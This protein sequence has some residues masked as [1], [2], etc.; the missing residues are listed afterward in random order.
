MDLVDALEILQIDK[1]E[2][3]SLTLEY[4]NRMNGLN[5]IMPQKN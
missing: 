3:N 1:H 5:F 4:L 2:I